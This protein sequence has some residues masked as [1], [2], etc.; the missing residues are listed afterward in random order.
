MRLSFP[1]IA[2][3]MALLSAG[4]AL[5]Q[6]LCVVEGNPA[7]IMG[8]DMNA[9]FNVQAGQGCTYDIRPGGTLSSSK[10]SQRPKHGT[11]KMID[12]DTLTYQPARGYHGPDSFA[13]TAKGRSIDEKPGTSVL[14]FRVNVQ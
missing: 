1:I 5:A 9:V 11:V 12:K 7:P 10:I 2:L 6:S 14:S 3:P 13:V 8:T 4:P